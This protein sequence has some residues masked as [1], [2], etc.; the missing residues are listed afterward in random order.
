MGRKAALSIKKD[1][2]DARRKCQDI[3]RRRRG[4]DDAAE[5][6]LS[7]SAFICG[8]KHS[9]DAGGDPINPAAAILSTKL[10][11]AKQ[12]LELQ[13]CQRAGGTAQTCKREVDAFSTCSEAHVGMVVQQ[14]VKIADKF[15]PNET[16]EV[17]R[18]RSIK[19]GDACEHEDLMA[20]RCA[21]RAVLESV[22]ADAA[23]ARARKAASSQ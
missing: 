9:M 10:Y 18:C 3:L 22:A 11:C 13:K 5:R 20:L 21:A 16:A 15:C 12:A 1:I 17:M 2:V 4:A 7:P 19:P 6:P 8:T 23:A 14:L